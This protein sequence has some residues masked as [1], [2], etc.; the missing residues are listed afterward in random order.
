MIIKQI[1]ENKSNK[2][3]LVSIPNNKGLKKGDYVSIIKVE[4]DQ[5]G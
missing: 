2:Q 4:E 1:Y 5:K 3:L